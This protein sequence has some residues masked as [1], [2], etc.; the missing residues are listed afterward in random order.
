M[1]SNEVFVV[2]LPDNKDKLEALTAFLKALKIDFAIAR[3][4]EYDPYFLQK[5]EEGEADILSG[6]TRKISLDEVWKLS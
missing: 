1:H 5:V 4:E 3:K 2:Q 6:N